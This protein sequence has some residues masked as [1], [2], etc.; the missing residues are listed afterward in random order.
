MIYKDKKVDFTPK[1]RKKPLVPQE[2]KKK[3]DKAAKMAEPKNDVPSDKMESSNIKITKMHIT[4]FSR[5]YFIKMFVSLVIAIIGG[6]M[7]CYTKDLICF[8]LIS[9]G[10]GVFLIELVDFKEAKYIEN[11]VGLENGKQEK[12]F[13]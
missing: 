10:V 4:V 13:S 9:S 7:L 12:S 8:L 2:P 5:S 1:L 6:V 3:V 11:K